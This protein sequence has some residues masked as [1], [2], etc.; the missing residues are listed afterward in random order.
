[1]ESSVI[2]AERIEHSIYAIRGKRVMLDSD[3]AEVYNVSTKVLN[4]QVKRNLDRFPE[5]FM[6]QLNR[7]EFNRL[8]SQIATA[9]L[10]KRRTAPYV[11]TEH[12]AVMLASVLNSPVAVDA[13]VQVV[14]AFVKLR[15]LLAS[16]AD[17]VRKIH[18]LEKKY[19]SQFSAVFKAINELMEPVEKGKKKVVGFRAGGK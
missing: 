10:T 5:D 3:L 16:H 9:S 4:Q 1:M 7:E 19:D 15:Q 14:R 12:G 6:F 2:P 11:F 18:A 17:L 8:Q 13:S